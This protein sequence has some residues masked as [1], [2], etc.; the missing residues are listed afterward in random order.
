MRRLSSL[1]IPLT[2]AL[3]LAASGLPAAAADVVKH[4][5]VIVA[6]DERAGTFVLAEVGPWQL[7]DG[8]TVV[9]RRTISLT[10]ATAFSIVFRDEE[11]P[12]GFPNDFVET[13]LE[14]WAVYLG[15][16]VTI[17]CRHDGRRLVALKIVVTDLPGEA[18]G[19]AGVR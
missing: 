6:V 5:G 9:T 7:R 12:S 10:P 2:L 8:E 13:P 16:H 14:P 4:S 1:A 15:D 3:L 11:A 19:A 18:F 17:D